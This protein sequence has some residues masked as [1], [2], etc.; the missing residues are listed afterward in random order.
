MKLHSLC[1]RKG[2]RDEY[3]RAETDLVELDATPSFKGGRIYSYGEEF[4]DLEDEDDNEKPHEDD[5]IKT[6]SFIDQSWL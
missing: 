4:D 2:F 3:T 5:T 1:K 6:K